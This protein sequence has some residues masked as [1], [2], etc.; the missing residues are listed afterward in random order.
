MRLNERSWRINISEFAPYSG[1]STCHP[2]FPASFLNEDLISKGFL[3][4]LENGKVPPTS[5]ELLQ[6]FSVQGSVNS[7]NAFSYSVERKS[8]SKL[9]FVPS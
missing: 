9:R 6:P 5:Q 7:S 2:G 4:S 3:L 1:F 8:V